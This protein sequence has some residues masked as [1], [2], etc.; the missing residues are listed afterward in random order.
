M[1]PRLTRWDTLRLVLQTVFSAR[2]SG[3]QTR[4]AGQSRHAGPCSAARQKSLSG[5]KHLLR[6]HVPARPQRIGALT[7]P[8]LAFA[9]CVLTL[10]L[11]ACSS[12]ATRPPDAAAKASVCVGDW[13][14]PAVD[15]TFAESL[16]VDAPEVLWSLDLDGS[17]GFEGVGPVLAGDRLVLTTK[18][19]LFSVEKDGSSVQEVAGPLDKNES[20]GFTLGPWSTAVFST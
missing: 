19:H 10:I 18:S 1:V 4:S 11:P 16:M 15:P 6:F 7:T 17:P 12:T 5:R 13:V 9:G 20:P 14:A 8:R 2:R 3:V